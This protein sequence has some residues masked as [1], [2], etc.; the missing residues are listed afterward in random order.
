LPWANL[1]FH[2][3]TLAAGMTP[4]V[5]SPAEERRF[6]ARIRTLLE[7]LARERVESI[8]LSEAAAEVASRGS[9]TAE[10]AC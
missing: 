8:T 3:P 7:H 4:F 5:R 9:R 6:L 10:P 1:T 2:T